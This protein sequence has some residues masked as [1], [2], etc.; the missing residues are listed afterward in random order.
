MGET[1]R[2]PGMGPTGEPGLKE[3]QGAV[4]QG[5]AGGWS[6]SSTACSQAGGSQ[7][8][9]RALGVGLALSV[10]G[11]IDSPPP[12]SPPTFTLASIHIQLSVPLRPQ[13]GGL[14]ELRGL[15]QRS[16]IHSY[17][18]APAFAPQLHLV[19]RGEKEPLGWP[20]VIPNAHEG[21]MRQALGPQGP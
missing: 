13:S 14:G 5:P 19:T 11:G 9:G 8:S 4:F 20:A 12:S 16:G 1:T 10:G 7:A 17:P 21:R 18:Q 6:V 2:R 3:A 15:S